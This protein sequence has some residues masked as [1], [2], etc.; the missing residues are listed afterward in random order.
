MTDANVDIV[1]SQIA[2]YFDREPADAYLAAFNPD[3]EDPFTVQDEVYGSV[4]DVAAV[5]EEIL[6][7]AATGESGALELTPT[8]R[9]P[10]VL[11]SDI[12]ARVTLLSEGVTAISKSSEEGRT[13]NIRLACTTLNGYILK[14]GKTFSFNNIVGKRTKANG[15]LEAPEYAYGELVTGIGGGVCQVSTTVYIAA[16]TSNLNILKRTKHSSPVNYT[17][18]GQDAT[19]YDGRIDFTFSNNTDGDLYLVA[20]VEQIK[21][22]KNRYQCVVRIYGPSLGEKVSYKLRSVQTQ[23][24]KPDPEPVY[25]K[26]TEGKYVTY[27]DET[28]KTQSAKDGSVIETYLQRWENGVMT[29]EKLITTDTYEPKRETYKVGV[30]R[31]PA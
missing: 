15:Y 24:L 8:P 23:T 2:A 9:A 31:R 16:V 7:R 11:A 20:K 13:S 17:L 21:G 6:R 28:Y 26:D 25:Q 22:T 4:L 3:A 19:V 10:A 5:K 30:K 12:R 29:E 18:K 1:L 14:Q 27:T